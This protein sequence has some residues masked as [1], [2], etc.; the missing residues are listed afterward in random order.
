MARLQS[1][2]AMSAAFCSMATIVRPESSTTAA[3][4]CCPFGVGANGTIVPALS[5]AY[6]LQP[7]MDV[8]KRTIVSSAERA[9]IWPCDDEDS[10]CGE[11]ITHKRSQTA[12]PRA[13]E[14]S[15]GKVKR[16]GWKPHRHRAGCASAVEHVAD[17]R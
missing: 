13:V 5:V 7:M 11:R 9:K 16:R 2:F 10:S 6:A 1:S 17:A 14:C 4:S 8:A 15:G 3:V 12:Q